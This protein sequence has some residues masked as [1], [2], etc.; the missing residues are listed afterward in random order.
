MCFVS[1]QIST[2][3]VF[4]HSLR[5]CGFPNS[6]GRK[7]DDGSFSVGNVGG[8][9]LYDAVLYDACEATACSVMPHD[10]GFHFSSIPHGSSLQRN[11]TWRNTWLIPS[12]SSS[13]FSLS[14]TFPPPSS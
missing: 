13:I 11:Y 6:V 12:R 3:S 14:H 9:W 5:T 7:P 4:C 10:S 2:N 8:C 1:S